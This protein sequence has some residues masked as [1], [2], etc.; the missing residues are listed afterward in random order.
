MNKY[1]LEQG[2]EKIKGR[3]KERGFLYEGTEIFEMIE[4]GTKYVA[5]DGSGRKMPGINR[6]TIEDYLHQLTIALEDLAT[7]S[8]NSIDTFHSFLDTLAILLAKDSDTHADDWEE[9]YVNHY[10]ALLME[11]EET[12]NNPEKGFRLHFWCLSPALGFKRLF[13][14]KCRN[15]ILTSGTLSPFYSFETELKIPFPIKISNPH[16]INTSTNLLAGV[17]NSGPLGNR[18]NF[19]FKKRD[20]TESLADLGELILH[21]TRHIPNG[22]LVFFASYQLMEA[23]YKLWTN[24]ENKI[25]RRIQEV[26][27]VI[28]EPR[29]SSEFQ[30]KL[31]QFSK[32]ACSSRGAILFAVCRGK[33]AEGLDF[34]D[35]LARAVF[36]VGV[37]FPPC[38]DRKVELKKSYLDTICKKKGIL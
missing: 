15:V 2:A 20:N 37:P 28:K 35:D 34:T 29:A 12:L 6:F 14:S 4:E 1:L 10:K 32:N 17:F 24:H 5:F 19:S 8:H 13:E 23:A 30:D 36:I 18:L 22:V 27:I 7:T 3:F 33:F 21:L 26:K 25:L 9:N 16:V 11:E 31:Q 38:Y